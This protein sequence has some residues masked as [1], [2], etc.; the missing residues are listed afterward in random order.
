MA[1]SVLLILGANCSENVLSKQEEDVGEAL[2]LIELSPEQV[3]FGG[4][5]AGETVTATI[6]VHNPGEIPL[7]V[8]EIVLESGAFSLVDD[9]GLSTSPLSPSGRTELVVAFTPVNPADT[10]WLVVHSDAA[11]DPEAR[12]QLDGASIASGIVLDPGSLT[13][14]DTEPGDTA[15]EAV[16][17]LNIGDAPLTVTSV[18]V[19]GDDAFVGVVDAAVPFVVDPNGAAVVDVSFSPGGYGRF[20][21]T[22]WVGSDAPAGPASASLYGTS[23]VPTAVCVADPEEIYAGYDT[24]DFLGHDSYDPHGDEIV[25]WDWTLV[26]K[27]SG[28]A[29]R[30]G[31]P[32]AN[33][34]VRGFFPDLAGTYEATLVVTNDLGVSSDPCVASLEAIPA[35]SLWVE[36]YWAHAGDDMDVH[37]QAGEMDVALLETDADC[38][39]ANCVGGGLDWGEVGESIDDPSLDLDDIPGVGPENVNIDQP[40]EGTYTVWV[41]DFDGSVWNGENEVTVK[42]YVDG[43]LVWTDERVLTTEG[44]AEAFCEVDWP[45]GEVRSL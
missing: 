23:G 16:T 42:V 43:E 31:A 22:L 38:Y 29:A 18:T 32:A 30:L 39:Y 4:V 21:G 25:S 14:G 45:S 17:I 28:S 35:Q 40:A 33:G 11:D 2:A 5:L 12:V 13:F 6:E 37:L 7:W 1:L 36:M 41:E 3:D 44:E 24:A 34:D 27:P 10:A 15:T 8:E 26:T 9:G 20:T 19:V